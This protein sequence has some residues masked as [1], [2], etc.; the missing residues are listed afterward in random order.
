MSD[1]ELKYQN[2]TL[3]IKINNGANFTLQGGQSTNATADVT[4][5]GG[6]LHIESKSDIMMKD[7]RLEDLDTLREDI[8]SKGRAEYIIGNNNENTVVS[9]R[10]NLNSLSGT[11]IFVQKQRHLTDC[12]LSLS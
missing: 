1:C 2:R 9:T 11:V 10:F 4:F 3:T 5:R 12:F 6:T 8:L 7:Y